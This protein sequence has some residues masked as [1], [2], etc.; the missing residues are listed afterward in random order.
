MNPKPNEATT[1][2]A[3]AQKLL[4]LPKKSLTHGQEQG[5]HASQYTAASL[6]TARLWPY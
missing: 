6:R 3:F 1:K 4:I 2:K 5:R